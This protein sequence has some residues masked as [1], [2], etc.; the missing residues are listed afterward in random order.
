MQAV[1]LSITIHRR[2]TKLEKSFGLKG[3]QLS[4][5]TRGWKSEDGNQFSATTQKQIKQTTT[6]F[7][8]LQP[9]QPFKVFVSVCLLKIIT[10]TEER[11]RNPGEQAVGLLRKWQT[12]WW[13]KK[14]RPYYWN[15]IASLMSSGSFGVKLTTTASSSSINNNNN[16][17]NSNNN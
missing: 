6:W 5:G 7:L 2:L 3:G 1:I 10:I 15:W 8:Q 16:N 11:I 17:N 4:A 13:P 9:H 12:Q 14:L